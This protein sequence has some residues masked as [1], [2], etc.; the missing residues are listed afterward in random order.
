MHTSTLLHASI[1]CG[2]LRMISSSASWLVTQESDVV[3]AC[4]ARLERQGGAGS[5]H[6]QHE[7]GRDQHRQRQFC[8]EEV[9][10][11]QQK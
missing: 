3:I 1:T 10:V 11:A 4:R 9:A 6:S 7:F 8:S 5:A 2:V